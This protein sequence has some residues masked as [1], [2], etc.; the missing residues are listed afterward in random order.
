MQYIPLGLNIIEFHHNFP[1]NVA[2][3]QKAIEDAL[4]LGKKYHLPVWLTEWQRLRPS[5]TGWGNEPLPREETYPDY[6]SLAAS[7]QKYPV[8]NFFWS[9]MVKRA[10]LPPQREKGTINGLFWPDGSVWSLADARAIAKDPA[11]NLVE[12]KSL[13]PGYLDYLQTGK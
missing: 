7:V 5:G 2:N 6:A 13:P 1:P 12:K 8:G 9:L 3:F 4:A 10:H 11:L